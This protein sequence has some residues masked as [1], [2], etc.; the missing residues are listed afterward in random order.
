MGLIDQIF[1]KPQASSAVQ[2]YFQTLTA[3]RPQ[4]VTY[5]GGIYEMDI[6]R[7][8]IHAF[9]T[10]AS[11]LKPEVNGAAGYMAKVLKTKPNPWQTTSQFL[12]SVAT[13]LEVDNTCFI[14]PLLNKSGDTIGLYPLPTE[15][16]EVV[17]YNGKPYLRF[18]FKTGKASVE[19]EKVGILTKMQYKD[20]FF[21]ENNKALM[22]TMNLIS[23]TNQNINEG[24]NNANSLRFMARLGSVVRPD[25]ME[26]ELK[27]FRELNFNAEN[28]GGVLMFDQKYADVKQIDSKAY[29]VDANQMQIINQNVF[30]YFG[31]NEKILRNEWDDQTMTAYYEGKIEPFAV[32]LSM[33]LTNM[34]YNEHERAF[35]NEITFSANRIQFAKTETKINMITQLFDRGILSFNEAREILQMPSVEGGDEFMIRGEYV[36]INDRKEGETDASSNNEGIQNNADDGTSGEQ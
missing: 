34:I 31:V 9:A 10:H 7:A 3:Y 26:K 17:E 12:Y 14:I 19:L 18:T 23:M 1:K 20:E 8:A 5:K 35:G 30:N 4:F 36:N 32:Q 2:N 27:K 25:D 22:P 33:V 13:I 29:V 16:A 6:T 24:I 21:G 11:K 15:T 28:N